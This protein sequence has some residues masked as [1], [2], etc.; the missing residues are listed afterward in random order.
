MNDE[1]ATS[2]REQAEM[3][4]ALIRY[5]YRGK[6]ADEMIDSFEAA[7]AAQDAPEARAGIYHYWI[8]YYRLKKYRRIKQRRRPTFKERLTACSACGYPTSHRHHLWDMAGHG[9]NRVTIQLCANCHELH[10]LMYNVLAR[11]SA[12]SKKL[13]AHILFSFRL[14]RHVVEQILG[15]CVATLRY[16]AAN[17]WIEG[18]KASDEWVEKQMRW[19]EYLERTVNS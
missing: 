12:Y 18:Y 14:P 13:L 2:E 16:E 9:E 15:W 10:H 4:Y 1:R 5:L 3:L 8:D 6:Q 17:G 19:S 11:D 7:L